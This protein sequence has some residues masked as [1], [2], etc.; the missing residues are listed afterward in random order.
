MNCCQTIRPFWG[1]I[2]PARPPVNTSRTRSTALMAFLS[3]LVTPEP[4]DTAEF[5]SKLPPGRLF[6]AF[7][8]SFWALAAI[9]VG[10]ILSLVCS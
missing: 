8:A 9:G 5:V 7:K 1:D 3:A 10:I 6:G 2:E 4:S